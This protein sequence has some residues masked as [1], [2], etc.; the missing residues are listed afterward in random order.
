MEQ[1]NNSSARNDTLPLLS[2][3]KHHREMRTPTMHAGSE[4]CTWQP[5][6]SMSERE[7]ANLV[8]ILCTD[9]YVCLDGSLDRLD[10]FPAAKFAK[11]WNRSETLR[12]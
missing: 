2:L 6:C 12:N 10:S 7:H 3:T 1:I 4:K 11:I 9:S 8:K 5:S